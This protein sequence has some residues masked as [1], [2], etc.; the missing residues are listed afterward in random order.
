[1]NSGEYCLKLYI[2]MIY[3]IPGE[4]EHRIAR[5]SGLRLLSVF[6][7]LPILAERG[8]RMKDATT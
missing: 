1:M 2:A 7:V 8:T 4:L 5:Y 3:A 6:E